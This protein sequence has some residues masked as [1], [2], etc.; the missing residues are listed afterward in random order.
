VRT[1]RT[2]SFDGFIGRSFPE[3]QIIN[4]KNVPHRESEGVRSFRG[5][6]QGRKRGSAGWTCTRQVPLINIIIRSYFGSGSG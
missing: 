2:C 3:A 5:R 4:P 1:Y 6:G